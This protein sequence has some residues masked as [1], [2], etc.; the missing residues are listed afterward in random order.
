MLPF[1]SDFQTG[2]GIHA[3]SGI[4][5]GALTPQTGRESGSSSK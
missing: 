5:V 3:A 4:F 1:D 2:C